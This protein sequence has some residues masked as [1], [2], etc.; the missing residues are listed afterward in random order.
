MITEVEELQA[1]EF[2]ER[3]QVRTMRKDLLMLREADALKERDKIVRMK[4]VEEEKLEKIKKGDEEKERHDRLERERILHRNIEEE[5][6]AEQQL[7][8][9]A[10]EAEKQQIF[11]LESERLGFERQIDIFKKQ[12]E[13]D[14]TLEKNDILLQKR[15]WEARLKSIIDEEQK[16]ETEQKFIEEKEKESNIPTEKKSLEERRDELDSQRQEIEK[17]RWAVEKELAKLEEKLKLVDDDYKRIIAEKNNL[18][19]KIAGTDKLLRGIYS[20]IIRRVEEKKR[21]EEAQ[22]K[23]EEVKKAEIELEKKESVQ[24]EQWTGVPQPPKKQDFLRAIPPSTKE[25]L[26]QGIQSEEE[27]RKQF[28]QNV[29]NW[30][31]DTLVP[32][33]K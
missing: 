18:K 6:E 1:K 7:K 5:K 17:K 15:D 31:E 16:I 26:I 3:A 22:Q 14:L 23:I 20:E 27:H 25:K 32:P 19:E 21:G 9:F 10:E 8:E 11:L 30:S 29:E 4:T 28:L 33:K 24:R 13:P 2:L 12:K